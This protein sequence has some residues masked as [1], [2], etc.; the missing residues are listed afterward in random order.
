[1]CIYQQKNIS[2]EIFIQNELDTISNNIL[3]R[4]FIDF[5][6]HYNQYIAGNEEKRQQ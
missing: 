4:D 5:F 6:P 1:M 3:Q 2:S